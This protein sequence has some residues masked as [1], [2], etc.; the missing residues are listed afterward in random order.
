MRY[1]M[2]ALGRGWNTVA[3]SLGLRSLPPVPTV[4][5]VLALGIVWPLSGEMF[6]RPADLASTLA[7]ERIGRFAAKQGAAE[8]APKVGPQGTTYSRRPV[9][10]WPADD[11]SQRFEIRL[12]RD[13]G[14]AWID[15]ATTTKHYF[16][17]SGALEPARAYSYSIAGFD[18]D[19]KPTTT[20][21]GQFT[22]QAM[23]AE[24]EAW[25]A[26]ANLEL[27][28]YE[29]A[30]VLAGRFAEKG[31][32]DDVVGGLIAARLA[33]PDTFAREV[34]ANKNARAFVARH[35]DPL[36]GGSDAP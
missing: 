34:G 15:R 6:N 31:S 1:L 33:D 14:S 9:L 18:A 27:N 13:D 11:K 17:V 8:D 4:A 21:K 20:H 30:L 22:V 19:G 5:T 23:D 24:F 12:L 26:N 7:V 10:R 16:V 28:S 29:S 25:Q 35:V 2:L 32:S 36:T 3:E